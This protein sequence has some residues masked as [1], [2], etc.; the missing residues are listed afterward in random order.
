MELTNKT[1]KTIQFILRKPDMTKLKAYATNLPEESQKILKGRY[2]NLLELL[3]VD[4]Q[5]DA[6]SA[7]AQYYDSQLR[8]FTFSNFQLAPTLEEFSVIVGQPLG[9]QN[10][11]TSM[12]AIL[13]LKLLL[14]PSE[15]MWVISTIKDPMRKRLKGYQGCVWKS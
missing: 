3:E 6:I 1:K 5:T 14:R 2:G 8:C 4:V 12:E 15:L 9:M 10:R 11:T 13:E 7:M